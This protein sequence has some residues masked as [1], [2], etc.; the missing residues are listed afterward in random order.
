MSDVVTTSSDSAPYWA[1]FRAGEVRLPVCTAC[2]K[3]HLPA[4]PVC[5]FCL[6]DALDWRPAVGRARL[7]T[8]LVVHEKVFAEFD[9][10][11]VVGQVQLEEGPRMTVSIP[12][13]AL[14]RLRM[15]MAGNVVLA[16][17]PNGMN[18]PQFRP[19]APV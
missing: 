19:D 8:W 14:Q 12:L 10:P 2:G 3:A 11:Y 16:T 4:G 15:D 13:D 17:A 1:G 7:S 5:P 9:P 6:S 18:L